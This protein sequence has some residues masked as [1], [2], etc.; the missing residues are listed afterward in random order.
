MPI[1]FDPWEKERKIS[2]YRASL[3]ESTEMILEDNRKIRGE[4]IELE[5]EEIRKDAAGDYF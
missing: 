4:L 1:D 5:R 3:E 2:L